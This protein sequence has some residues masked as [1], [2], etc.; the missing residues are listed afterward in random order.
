MSKE[1]HFISLW[2]LYS[3]QLNRSSTVVGPSGQFSASASFRILLWIDCDASASPQSSS[4]SAFPSAFPS[5]V[6]LLWRQVAFALA[7]RFPAAG[8]WSATSFTVVSATSPWSLTPAASPWQL[9][10]ELELVESVDNEL[11]PDLADLGPGL[12]SDRFGEV[13]LFPMLQQAMVKQDVKGATSRYRCPGPNDISIF[14]WLTYLELMTDDW[15]L[16]SDA[17]IQ[18]ITQFNSAAARWPR[19]RTAKL[20]PMTDQLTDYNC[21]N[22]YNCCNL[23]LLQ[24]TTVTTVTTAHT[25]TTVCIST[26]PPPAAQW[27]QNYLVVKQKQKQIQD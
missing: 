26:L 22:C 23:Q 8:G 13:F 11:V 24:L 20:N 5:D 10:D 16:M 7:R 4:L 6:A 25:V 21:Y 2:Q 1:S 9:E 3:A 15:W 17:A 12:S 19:S 14:D 27:C 18:C